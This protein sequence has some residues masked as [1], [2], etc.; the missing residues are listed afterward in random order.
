MRLVLS[1]LL[2]CAPAAPFTTACPFA[3]DAHPP[4]FPHPYSIAHQYFSGATTA[5]ERTAVLIVGGDA[6]TE[7]SAA[8]LVAAA[9]CFTIAR[10]SDAAVSAEKAGEFSAALGAS[11]AG[12]PESLEG[13]GVAVLIVEGIDAVFKMAN[14]CRTSA[15]ASQLA[16]L[17]DA[18]A[19]NASTT[20]WFSDALPVEQTLALIS[21]DALAQRSALLAEGFTV[22]AERKI[23]LSQASAEDFLA[24]QKET[25]EFADLVAAAAAAPLIALCLAKPGAVAHAAARCGSLAA[26][27]PFIHA[28]ASSDAAMA[29]I[30]FFFAHLL[31]RP[32]P[33]S[34]GAGEF[35]AT[36]PAKGDPA[37]GSFSAIL[38]EGL[39]ALCKAK[40][41][42]GAAAVK[43][44]GTWFEEYNGGAAEGGAEAESASDDGT[45]ADST[46]IPLAA[47]PAK[48]VVLIAGADEAQA[49][50]A[51][52]LATQCGWTVI[53]ASTAAEVQTVVEAS[54]ETR[55]VVVGL[56]EKAEALA[57]EATVAT[58]SFVAS[59]SGV[60]DV[61][62]AGSVVSFYRKIGRV[63]DITAAS[64]AATADALKAL[65]LPTIVPIL[66][67]AVGAAELTAASVLVGGGT[68]I[69]MS[70]LLAEE[71][72]KGSAIGM[73]VAAMKANSHT[74]P[75][76]ACI[77][78][79]KVAISRTWGQRILLTGFPNTLEDARVLEAE[80]GGVRAAVHVVSAAS[81]VTGE[82]LK[83]YDSRA[84]LS[85]AADASAAAVA[86]TLAPNLS[87][88]LGPPQS[89]QSAM[90][91]RLADRLSYRCIS[92]NALMRTEL[93]RQSAIGLEIQQYAIS[94]QV[95]P[96]ALPLGL[97]K[98]EI[99]SAVGRGCTRFILDGWPSSVDQHAEFE[100]T[101]AP[102]SQVL[103]L[104]CSLESLEQRRPESMPAAA[105][106]DKLAQWQ[107]QGL[108]LIDAAAARGIVQTVDGTMADDEVEAALL[109]LLVPRLVPFF[110]NG[111]GDL[112]D[113]AMAV[114]AA[115]G[116]KTLDVAAAIADAPDT[117]TKIAALK[118]A[119]ESTSDGR[120]VLTGFP[121]AA[122]EA[123]ALEATFGAPKIAVTVATA[124]VKE[125]GGEEEEAPEPEEGEEGA[126]PVEDAG[127]AVVDPTVLAHYQRELFSITPGA[128]GELELAELRTAFQPLVWVLVAADGNVRT[129][130]VL[131]RAARDRGY[132]VLRASAIF[133]AEIAKGTPAGRALA[134]AIA[135]RRTVPAAV[136]V[137]LL[138]AKMQ[139][140]IGSKFIVEGFPRAISMGFPMVHDQV[141]ELEAKVGNVHNVL[142]LDNDV[143]AGVAFSGDVSNAAAAALFK[144]EQRPIVDH[145][146]TLG[147][148]FTVRTNEYEREGGGG[149]ERER[150]GPLNV[151]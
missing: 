62:P 61:D 66:G 83:H 64:S 93:E 65:L 104:Q 103:Y 127:V 144:K 60:A 123:Q 81:P 94:K 106:Q 97:I 148:V 119:L 49:S 53:E 14:V 46:L 100:A 130:E 98:K 37:K 87:I 120:Y 8:S 58:P 109:T 121:L 116:Y 28:S 23:A 145:F 27:T 149:R 118:R 92:A 112:A 57:L 128:E 34:A 73:D 137:A 21:V 11:F 4:P 105:L 45:A 143:T 115:A 101:V 146:A 31:E 82:L 99:A 43:W 48:R 1:L 107:A 138:S 113:S 35:L 141:F 22:I 16:A 68:I 47:D 108:P 67:G 76:S 132:A 20:F 122:E 133:A 85:V 96:T 25:P 142:L 77:T 3:L 71:E 125:D 41:A 140:C 147:K 72:A 151:V 114:C 59:F 18:S 7:E 74:P 9:G 2:L 15:I 150:D 13:S 136:A 5:F 135:Q 89:A 86:A 42:P 88:V 52:E 126:A 124:P 30:R 79:L 32:I 78:V 54:Y 55:F 19:V 51:K 50:A 102:V 110:A 80:I 95:V 129:D 26:A 38:V 90:C 131:A 117:A 10:A 75:T 91:K 139:S 44:L 17:T 63:H 111:G 40:P 56:T 12:L 84:M 69:S 33:T 36:A 70:A 6:A 39:V 134:T 29:E 24:A